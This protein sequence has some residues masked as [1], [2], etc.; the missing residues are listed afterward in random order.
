MMNEEL[1]ISRGATA[2]VVPAQLIQALV[3]IA[4]NTEQGAALMAG[5]RIA[6]GLYEG[7]YNVEVAQAGKLVP[8]ETAPSA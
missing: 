1:Q 6:L 8:A 4:L 7:R 5:F 3:S 2:K